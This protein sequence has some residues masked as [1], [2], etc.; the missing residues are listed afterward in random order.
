M[1]GSWPDTSSENFLSRE[2]RHIGIISADEPFET[3]VDILVLD[4]GI[5]T[6]LM[7]R[8]HFHGIGTS[9]ECYCGAIQRALERRI[10]R[11]FVDG[12]SGQNSTFALVFGHLVV[13]DM[14]PVVVVGAIRRMRIICPAT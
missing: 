5:E 1:P 14:A 7:P 11:I 13:L 8:F 12:F 4:D 2:I 3:T 6:S 9:G 10:E